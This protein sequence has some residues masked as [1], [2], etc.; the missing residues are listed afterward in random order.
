M[1]IVFLAFSRV[2]S[3]PLYKRPK[4]KIDGFCP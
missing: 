4:D 2:Y 3:F 1:N